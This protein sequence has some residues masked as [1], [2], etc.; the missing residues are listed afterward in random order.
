MYLTVL[1]TMQVCKRVDKIWH[2]W[3]QWS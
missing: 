2:S 1:K 3:L